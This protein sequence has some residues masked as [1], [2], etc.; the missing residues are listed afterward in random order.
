MELIARNVVKVEVPGGGWVDLRSRIA[1]WE[2]SK[3]R[4]AA[5]AMKLSDASNAGIDYAA[6]VQ[7]GMEIG[8]VAWSLDEELTADNIKALDE[9]S[10]DFIAT[11]LNELWEPRSD[12][13]VK[14]SASDGATPS[15]EKA[16]PPKES[17]G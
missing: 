7:A 12:D 4:S 2:R 17:A 6:T 10:Y 3:I 13:E 15:E 9:E 5:I 14:N 11:K 16:Q 1:G 8:I